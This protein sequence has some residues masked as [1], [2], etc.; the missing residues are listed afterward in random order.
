MR[1]LLDTNA[2]VWWIGDDARLGRS[3]RTL[4]GDPD[5]DVF[6][7][8]A[9][10]W[11]IAIKRAK[12]KLTFGD[13][14]DALEE[15]SFEPLPIEVAHG[16]AAGGLPPHHRDPFDRVLIAQAQHHGLAIVTADGA[17]ARY[18]VALVPADR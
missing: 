16:V 9:T 2:F 11:E 8:A 14:A 17:F 5:N 3:A 12:G 7:S 10:A 4:I 18:D 6:V 15:N 13:V 1:L